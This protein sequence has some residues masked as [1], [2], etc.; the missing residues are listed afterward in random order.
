MT[1]I[2]E[3]FSGNQLITL[4]NPAIPPVWNTVRGH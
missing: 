1:A 2:N 4:L 3:A